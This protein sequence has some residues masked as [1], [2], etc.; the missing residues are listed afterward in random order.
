M[1]VGEAESES[2]RQI[3]DHASVYKADTCGCTQTCLKLFFLIG[4]MDF[5]G[6]LKNE[7][8]THG[9]KRRG[10]NGLAVKSYTVAILGK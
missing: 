9:R 6:G 7:I 1:V 5:P 8:R 10:S 3:T 2:E 4:W